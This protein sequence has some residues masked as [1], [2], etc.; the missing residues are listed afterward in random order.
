MADKIEWAVLEP[1]FRGIRVVKG[2]L[3][4]RGEAEAWLV[5]LSI[6]EE[7]TDHEHFME[8]NGIVCRQPMELGWRRIDRWHSAIEDPA[9]NP[10]VR[11]VGDTTGATDANQERRPPS[12]T[13]VPVRGAVDNTSAE[14]RTGG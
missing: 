6:A 3:G 5:A 9:T 8:T 14:P 2:G 12:P 10:S 1:V 11:C 13:N 4:S 7:R